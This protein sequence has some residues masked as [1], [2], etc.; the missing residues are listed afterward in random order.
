M[1]SRTSEREQKT[2]ARESVHGSKR[3]V[4]AFPF[5]FL[6]PLKRERKWLCGWFETA[7]TVG[8]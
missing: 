2:T 6:L 8:K 4:K 3:K 5:C 1:H 7:S